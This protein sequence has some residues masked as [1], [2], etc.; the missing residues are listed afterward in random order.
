M[1]QIIQHHIK[2]DRI[3]QWMRDMV[4]NKEVR[5]AEMLQ[6]LDELAKS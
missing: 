6:K 2:I 4:R 1:G 5:K 3:P